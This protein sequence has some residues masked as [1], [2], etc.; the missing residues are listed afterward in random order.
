MA[1][2]PIPC[3]A[4]RNPKGILRCAELPGTFRAKRKPLAYANE[5]DYHLP[6]SDQRQPSSPPPTRRDDAPGRKLLRSEDLFGTSN[7]LVILHDGEEYRLRITRNN[8]L[9]LTK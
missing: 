7:E 8:K 6:M 5:N 2:V 1:D 3:H 4:A 9:I